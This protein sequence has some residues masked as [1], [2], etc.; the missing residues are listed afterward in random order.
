[1]AHAG[2]RSDASEVT[3]APEKMMFVP[4]WKDY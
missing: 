2:M 3:D 4:L 1:M